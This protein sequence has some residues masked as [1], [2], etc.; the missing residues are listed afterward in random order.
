M[1]SGVNA[2][3]R[4]KRIDFEVAP[5]T[6]YIGIFLY[7]AADLQYNPRALLIK[8]FFPFFLGMPRPSFGL[9]KKIY[10][11]RFKI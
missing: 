7:A 10:R 2:I 3:F 5:S 9:Q 1:K 11:G 4:Y 6:D 8:F